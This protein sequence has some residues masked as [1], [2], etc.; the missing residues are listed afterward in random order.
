MDQK[1]Y[2]IMGAGAVGRHLAR[3]LSVEGHAVTLIDS[4]PAKRQIV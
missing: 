1:R 4:N 2:V 3:A